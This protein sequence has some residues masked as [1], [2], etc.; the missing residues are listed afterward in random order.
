MP[1][2]I[3]CAQCGIELFQFKKALSEQGRVVNLVEPHTCKE[4]NEC[5]F[6]PISKDEEVEICYAGAEISGDTPCTVEYSLKCELAIEARKT[7]ELKP[8]EKKPPSNASTFFDSFKFVQK[9]NKLNPI[10]KTEELKTG[11]LRNG[12]SMRKEIQTSSAPSGILDAVKR[13]PATKEI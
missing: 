10:K 12:D 1:N 9:L 4:L 2:H 8:I 5:E 13:M 11:D 3:F 7:E 6:W